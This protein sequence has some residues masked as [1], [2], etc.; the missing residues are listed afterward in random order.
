MSRSLRVRDAVLFLQVVTE[1]L[2]MYI[3]RVSFK[4]LV[5]RIVLSAGKKE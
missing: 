2:K 5:L 3:I 1:A 4:C